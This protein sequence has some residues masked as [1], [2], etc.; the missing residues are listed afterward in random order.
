MVSM[1]PQMREQIEQVIIASV[2]YT[3]LPLDFDKLEK[4]E[5]FL[6]EPVAAKFNTTVISGFTA[7]LER[8]IDKLAAAL[9]RIF[10]NQEQQI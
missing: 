6:L 2:V 4:H 9:A 8:S 5:S 3:Y 1:R 7:G 10:S